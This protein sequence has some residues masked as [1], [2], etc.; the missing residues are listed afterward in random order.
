MRLEFHPST[1]A[2]VRDATS[3]YD[4]QRAA[5]GARFLRQ[6]DQALA[7]IARSPLLFPLVEHEVRRALVK[8][9]PYT[10]LFRVLGDNVVRILVTRH[11]R[12]DPRFGG[13]RR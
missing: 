7:Q 13:T 10:V 6:L 5:L 1:T 12:R 11:H 4:K 3:Y 2:D 8:N 9:F